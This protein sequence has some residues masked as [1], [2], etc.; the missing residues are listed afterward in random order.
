[1]AVDRAG[2]RHIMSFA[3]GKTVKQ[4]STASQ[5]VKGT[6]TIV[7]F[8][9]DP[10]IF[11]STRFDFAILESRLRE[12]AFLNKGLTIALKD[13]REGQQKDETFYYKGGIAEFVAWLNTNKKPLHPRPI[14]IETMKDDVDI[15]IALQYDGGYQ[16][17][18]LTFVNN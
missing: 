18:T 9:P 17:N 6:G 10:E 15:Q 7:R 8:K 3:R 2:K 1:V 14:L 16:E 5:P 4:L 13:E 12:L 11:D